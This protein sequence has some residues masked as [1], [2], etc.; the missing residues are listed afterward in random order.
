[1]TLS[2]ITV[3]NL[4]ALVR[5]GESP[6][7]EFKRNLPPESVLA[8]DLSAFANADG[9]TL[10]IGV[11]EKG[12]IVGIPDPELPRL[13]RRI[14][15]VAMSLLPRPAIL[16]H[17]AVD[18]KNVAYVLIEPA[19]DSAKPIL[20]A[21]GQAFRRVGSTSL[22][23]D[24]D[25]FI[26]KLLT[27]PTLRRRDIRVFVAMSFRAEEEPALEDYY[28]AMERAV[29]AARLPISMTRMDLVEGD[30]EISQ[31]IM[32]EID[33][34]DIVVADFTLAP[35]NVYFEL[36]YARGKRKRVIQ[37]SRKGT[38]LEFDVRSWRTELYRNATELEEKMETAL[39]AA[40]SDVTQV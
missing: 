28:R 17:V 9:G 6:T 1:M 8:A 33:R 12:E 31:Q 24:T 32:D 4:R 5:G 18:G 14:D 26:D 21:K 2:N 20:T 7:V 37:T 29:G 15:R 34:A 13:L 38:R 35:A 23:V 27:H 36:G 11:N 16:G 40:Y 25:A 3:A 10:L 22:K 30:Y 19:P 39:R